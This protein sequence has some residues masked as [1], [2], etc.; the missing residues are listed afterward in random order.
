MK[1]FVIILFLAIGTLVL[2]ECRVQKKITYNIPPG[3]NKEQQET[4]LTEMKKGSEM[5]KTNCSG[6]HGIFTKGKDGVPNFTHE[7]VDNYTS[8]YIK[9]DKKNHAVAIDMSPQQFFTIMSFLS[10]R[11]VDTTGH[12]VITPARPVIKF[13]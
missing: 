4:F 11:K 13:D 12:K 9:G 6:C 2:S 8:G 3:Y 1:R 7:Q 5:F 10:A